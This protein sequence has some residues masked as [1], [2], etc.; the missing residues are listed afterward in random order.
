MTVQ[1]DCDT[2]GIAPHVV[3]YY[4]E[5][6]FLSPAR[7]VRNAYREHGESD[8]HRLKFI[9]RAKALGFTLQEID[10]ILQGADGRVAFVAHV[11]ELVKSRA[12]A[13][14]ARITEAQ[15]V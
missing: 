5:R 15:R 1:R 10:L 6:G 11:S 7:N 14:E 13:I 9:C 2:V 8:V 3:R 4:S 12:M